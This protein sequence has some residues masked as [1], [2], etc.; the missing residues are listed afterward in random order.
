MLN[1]SYLQHEA[2][3][4]IVLIFFFFFIM[5]SEKT[6]DEIQILRRYIAT[7]AQN[8]LDLFLLKDKQERKK[9]KVGIFK[10]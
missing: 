10:T 2:Q 1:K 5:T 3:Q 4:K 8:N 9:I 7:M 6:S